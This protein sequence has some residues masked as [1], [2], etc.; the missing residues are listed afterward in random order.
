MSKKLLEIACFGLEPALIAQL[1]GADRI[2]LCED[3]SSGGFSPTL[4][5]VKKARKL[6]KIP[7]HV[8]IRP[9]PADL[10]GLLPLSGPKG[11]YYTEKEIQWMTGFTT[12]CQLEGIDG[13]AFGALTKQKEVDG[14]ACS[15]II[16]AAKNMSLTFHRAVDDCVDM[17][18]AMAQI[19]SLGFHRV[20][21]SGGKANAPEGLQT[22]T[23]LQKDFGNKIIIMPGGGIRSDNIKNI[24]NTGCK[25]FHSAA[26]TGNVI[27][28]DPREIEHIKRFL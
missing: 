15:R 17:R 2:E 10:T 5:E 27:A 20:L 22:L 7:L 14:H 24:L 11:F 9:R 28:P 12:A 26:I 21:T 8:M 19:V 4:D 23:Q 6:I 13:I 1:A 25:E 16:E 18:A 3:Y